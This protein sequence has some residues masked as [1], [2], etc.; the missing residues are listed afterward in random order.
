MRRGPNY[1]NVRILLAITDAS[2]LFV[3]GKINL[4]E[5]ITV[6]TSSLRDMFDARSFPDG[7]Q[8]ALGRGGEFSDRKSLTERMKDSTIV[9][10]GGH[11]LRDLRITN[12]DQQVG[13]IP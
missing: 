4:R 11:I 8:P 13:T 1:L 3:Q 6:L 7:W 2:G 9:L 5:F 12:I 10:K